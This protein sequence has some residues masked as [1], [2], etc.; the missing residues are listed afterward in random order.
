[1]QSHIDLFN[2]LQIS[3]ASSVSSLSDRTRFRNFFR[4][5]PSSVENFVPTLLSVLNHYD[6]NRIMFLTQ[7]ENIFNK[8]QSL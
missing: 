7:N 2:H 8:V 5:Y 3:F 4:T 1:M 6:W